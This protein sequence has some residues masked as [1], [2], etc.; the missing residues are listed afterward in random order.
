[1]G[2]AKLIVISGGKLDLAM[3]LI[4]SPLIRKLVERKRR[5]F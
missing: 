4:L 3:Q 2:R 1:M 5:S